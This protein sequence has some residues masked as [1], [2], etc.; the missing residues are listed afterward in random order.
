MVSQQ[1]IQDPGIDIQISM[2]L[3]LTPLTHYEN[4]IQN[5]I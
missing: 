5:G 2:V 4:Q 1:V 3:E